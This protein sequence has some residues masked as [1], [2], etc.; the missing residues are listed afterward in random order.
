MEVKPELIQNE[1]SNYIKLAKTGHYPLF[2]GEWINDGLKD[3]KKI[4]VSR[5]NKKVKE[6]FERLS[7]HRS[8]TRK[9]TYL[10]SLSDEERTEF[11]QSFYKVVEHNIISEL[12]GFH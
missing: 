1:I 9:Q 2:F 4:A 3:D 7:T 11:I 10:M 8:E 5:A 6:I 12:K